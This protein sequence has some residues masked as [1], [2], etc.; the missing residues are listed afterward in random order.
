MLACLLKTNDILISMY[1]KIPSNSMYF[2]STIFADRF[3]V[4]IVKTSDLRCLFKTL[5]FFNSLKTIMQINYLVANL[6]LTDS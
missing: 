3:G 5:K 2:K 1:L 4:T 6:K